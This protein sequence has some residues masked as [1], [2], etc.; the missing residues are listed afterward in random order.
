MGGTTAQPLSAGDAVLGLVIELPGNS[1][2]LEQRLEARFGSSRFS[3]ATAYHALKRLSKQGLIRPIEDSSPGAQSAASADADAD[4]DVDVADLPATAYEA[5]PA[6]IA[7]FR[8]W[9]RASTATPPV[10]EELQAKIA[11]CG[12]ED[13]PRMVAIVREAELACAA[14]LEDLNQRMRRQRLLDRD[15]AWR[16]LTG[17]IV[18]AADVAWWDARIKWLQTLRQYLQREGQ[19]YAAEQRQASSPPRD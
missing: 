19:R 1:Y 17:M 12:P 15:D 18:T 5:T 11:F 3:H 8:R 7:H 10:R 16:R 13:L 2:Q 6:G 9:L 4:V 14:Q